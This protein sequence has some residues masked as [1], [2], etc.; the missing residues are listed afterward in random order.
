MRLPGIAL[1]SLAVLLGGAQ[2]A[3]CA[4]EP[5]Q[6]ATGQV[7]DDSVVTGKVKTAIARD[8]SLSA[9]KDIN[10]TTYRGVVQLSGFVESEQTSRRAEEIAKGVEGVRSVENALRVNP[11]RG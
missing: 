11:P 10:V 6:R 7:L 4:S 1:V 5:G 3:G 2:L 8:A 9:A